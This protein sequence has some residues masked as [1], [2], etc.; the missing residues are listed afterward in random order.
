MSADFMNNVN[1]MRKRA[2]AVLKKH[3]QGLSLQRISRE[4]NLV[5]HEIP[6]LKKDLQELENK[7]LIYQ[8]K[9]RYILRSQKQLVLGEV[10][11]VHRGYAWVRPEETDSQDIFV[12]ARFAGGA[13]LGDRVEVVREEKHEEA[14]PEGRVLRV[15]ERKRRLLTGMYKEYWGQSF[16]QSYESPSKEEIP[17][18]VPGDMHV[19][20]GQIIEVDRKTRVVKTILGGLDDPGVDVE[21]IVRKYSLREHFSTE[22]SH[23][24]EKVSTSIP[25][26][27]IQ[28]RQDYRDWVTF[29]VDGEDA[30]DFD[31]AI[32]IRSL[33]EG[34]LLLG[35]H[36]ADVSYYVRPGSALDQEAYLR[37]C[38]VYF[39]DSVLPMLPEK[40]SNEV[41]SLRPDEDRLS[42]SVLLEVDTEGQVI[43][44]RFFPSIIRSDARLTYSEVFQ[45]FE[46]NSMPRE[47]LSRLH[48]ELRLMRDL[49]A[50]LRERRIAGGSLDIVSAEPHLIYQD[51]KL[52]GV[53][54]DLPNEAHG[55]IEEFMLAANEAV[56]HY[57]AGQH[58]P[59]VFRAHPNPSV[60][61]LAELRALMVHFGVSLPEPKTIGVRD[62]QKALQKAEGQSWERLF[63]L[64][65]LRSL[66]LAVYSTENLGHFGLGKDFYLH[67]T[68]PIRRYPDLLVHRCL[69]QVLKAKDVDGSSFAA[70]ATWSSDRE[71]QSEAAE[72]ELREWRIY[73]LLHKRLGDVFQGFITDI[74]KAGV[75]VELNDYF[76]S[77]IILYQDLGKDYYVRK[78]EASVSGR[79]TGETFTL[80]DHIPVSLVAVDPELRRMTLVPMPGQNV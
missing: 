4:L 60:H 39:P 41:C 46:G 20:S 23:E 78:S 50:K 51:A 48:P 57:L 55:M 74:N 11:A 35:V 70:A 37:G 58:T 30:R 40:L 47:I 10:F 43:S 56:A 33:P 76:V 31:D 63:S 65:I 53:E 73:R 18:L 12:P 15:I 1:T 77:G 80:G 59:C 64:K 19:S 72:K 38:S 8:A 29:T 66:K 28:A 68:S 2:L 49:A 75:V 36:I 17:I 67:F 7:G 61:A 3:P 24:A 16:F 21:I 79:K 25:S 54:A 44:R 42:F 27:E 34:R 71:R 69:N 45:V 62:L 5:R 9:R 26:H 14:R 22:A 13:L 6:L 52:V 32:S